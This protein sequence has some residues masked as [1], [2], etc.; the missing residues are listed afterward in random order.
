M[1]T[2]NID[3]EKGMTGTVEQLTAEYGLLWHITSPV[4]KDLWYGSPS[5]IPATYVDSLGRDQIA[6]IDNGYVHFDENY[7]GELGEAS[8]PLD[9]VI[10]TNM[11]VG[12]TQ[13]VSIKSSYKTWNIDG[14]KGMTGTVEQ[15]TA[16]YGLLWHITSPVVKDL[17]YGSPSAIP[18]TYVDSLGRDQIAVID[19]GYVHFDENYTGELGEASLPLDQV[20]IT[21]MGVGYTQRVSI[22][23]VCIPN[24]Q[25]E[26]DGMGYNTGYK[27]DG[28]GNREQD[29]DTCPPLFEKSSNVVFYLAMGG[30][31]L[32]GLSILKTKKI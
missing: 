29:I 14:E 15:L 32:I 5:A 9:Q 21:N 30:L 20:I 8:L 31:G 2:W 25:C 27:V 3:G 22:K 13:R 1:I 18:A 24:W 17:W 6:V 23:E 4:V 16:E 28:C 11:G 19:N 12:Y 7:T 10:I 26:I